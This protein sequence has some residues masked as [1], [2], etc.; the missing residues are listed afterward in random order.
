MVRAKEEPSKVQSF[1]FP[2]RLLKL[3]R[4][5]ADENN[6]SLNAQVWTML[7]D[8]LQSHGHLG[9]SERRR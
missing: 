8:W 5:L 9:K 2:V 7:E 3:L 4:S 6:R 1:R